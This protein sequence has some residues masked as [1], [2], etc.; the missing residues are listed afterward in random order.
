MFFTVLHQ[1]CMTFFRRP[2]FDSI[3]HTSCPS[4]M[5]NAE[6]S[7]T[8]LENEMWFVLA[9]YLR[10]ENKTVLL[11]NIYLLLVFFLSKI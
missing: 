8:A 9:T 11:L 10:L 2:S 4:H 1:N 5:I 3:L 6:M 7:V